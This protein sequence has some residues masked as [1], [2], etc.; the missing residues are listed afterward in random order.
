MIRKKLNNEPEPEQE[1][2]KPAQP[3][4][5]KTIPSQEGTG[6]DEDAVDAAGNTGTTGASGNTGASGKTDANSG[7]IGASVQP[8]DTAAIRGELAP[9]TDDEAVTGEP[10]VGNTARLAGEIVFLFGK[11]NIASMQQAFA[12]LN[13]LPGNEEDS[14]ASW[15]THIFDSYFTRRQIEDLCGYYNGFKNK[16]QKQQEKAQLALETLLKDVS[17]LREQLGSLENTRKIQEESLAESQRKLKAALPAPAVS[18]WLCNEL[19]P[20]FVSLKALLIDEAGDEAALKCRFII[21]L[22]PS[23]WGLA[24][25]LSDQLRDNEENRGRIDAALMKVLAAITGLHI[26]NRREVLDAIAKVCSDSTGNWVFVSPESSLV[27]DP[28]IHNAKALSG[29]TV[30]EGISFA[31]IRK[32]SRQT[33]KLADITVI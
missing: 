17:G 12:R 23:L 22:L 26:I 28:A 2:A 3:L 10:V 8:S 13:I 11:D 24:G 30:K 5:R 31:I 21:K 19:P 29:T 4:G 32:D 18:Q 16:E 1:G 14:P 25:V 6:G 15:L 33:I 7:N 9:S 27:V 20:I